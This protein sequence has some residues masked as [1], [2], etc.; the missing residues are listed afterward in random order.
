[1]SHVRHAGILPFGAVSI[2]MLSAVIH[3]PVQADDIERGSIPPVTLVQLAPSKRPSAPDK[4]K[5][6]VQNEPWVKKAEH[7]RKTGDIESLS[8]LVRRRLRDQ[9]DSALGLT[10]RALVLSVD[11]RYDEAMEAVNKA[12][13]LKKGNAL[14]YDIRGGI[15]KG[16]ADYD[17]ALRDYNEA[18]RL[19]PQ[20][21][22][23]VT[24]RGWCCCSMSS[25]DRAIAAANQAL[26]I[27][28]QSAASYWLRA[29]AKY[30]AAGG[31][32]LGLATDAAPRDAHEA[33]RLY[34][35]QVTSDP[36]DQTA[37]RGLAAAQ[38]WS[39]DFAKSI[40]SFN[41]IMQNGWARTEDFVNRGAGYQLLEQYERAIADFTRAVQH[42]PRNAEAYQR[43]AQVYDHMKRYDD[44]V[45]DAT[46]AIQLDPKNAVAY[47]A[48]GVAY[49]WTNRGHAARADYE[50]ALRIDPGYTEA[51]DSLRKLK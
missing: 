30:G 49:S 26:Q 15:Y 6:D 36:K 27:E 21:V 40:E 18:V 43:R 31:G 20:S 5:Q 17:A 4:V 51:R 39:G 50:Q 3:E 28:P 16:K 35:K 29:A 48:R 8:T 1:M 42:S 46:E 7:F 9:P 38:N 45:R 32:G 19:A 22:E 37:L 24:D 33:I 23:F 41:T 47:C 10:Y 14:A 44:A 34:E 25:H 2:I 12:I 13:R 11:E